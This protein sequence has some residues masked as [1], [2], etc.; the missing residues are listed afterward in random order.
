MCHNKDWIYTAHKR[1]QLQIFINCVKPSACIQEVCSNKTCSGIILGKGVEA[2]KT[3]H[4]CQWG[5]HSTYIL[6]NGSHLQ[7]LPR[8]LLEPLHHHRLNVTS[9][10]NQ[11]PFLV[12]CAFLKGLTT[13]KSRGELYGRWYI[14]YI[15]WTLQAS[16]RQTSSHNMMTLVIHM[17]GHFH[18]MG[19]ESLGRLHNSAVHW[20]WHQHQWRAVHFMSNKH[21][22]AL[23]VQG[24]RQRPTLFINEMIKLLMSMRGMSQCP[25]EISLMA[26]SLSRMIPTWVSL[27][28]PLE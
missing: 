21:V 14:E 12:C 22:K 5:R 26:F 18:V 4:C 11:E 19:Y 24:F 20:W 10:L 23:V 8:L 27:E 2:I 15:S 7:K 3:N 1:V 6:A 25:M 9:N 16:W 17:L 13:P 28:Q